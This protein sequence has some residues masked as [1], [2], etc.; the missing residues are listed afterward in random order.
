MN[1]IIK[2]FISAVK[3]HCWIIILSFL[4][5]ILIFAPLIAFP[6]VIKNE[7]Q[8]ININ[9]FGA[10]AHFYFSRAREVLDGHGL[11]SPWLREGKNDAD[12][13]FSYVDYI[14]LAPI[15]LLGLEQ[16]VDLVAIYNI[17]NFIG[18]FFI[19]LM[20]YFLVYQLSGKKIL[21]AAAALFVVGGYSIIFHQALFYDDSNIYSRIIDP[22]FA[23]LI[24]F[25][26]LNLLVKASKSAEVKY[27]I[28]S[29]LTFGLLFYIYFYAWSF[30]LALN[31]SLFLVLLIKKDF[32]SAKKILFISLVGL[33][34]GSYTLIGL[35]SSLGSAYGEQ[36][37][38][39]ILMS[40]GHRPVFS[41]I[42]LI[43][44]VLL[45]I[46]WYKKRDDQNLPFISAIILAGWIALNQQIITGK[47]I[48]YG[49][50]YWY[51]VVPLSI[52]TG[53]YLIWSLIKNEKLKNYLFIFIIFIVFINTIGGQY[54]SFFF[55]LEA[56]K[57]EQ[58]FRSLIDYLN[59]DNQSAVILAVEGANE[60][61]FTI[62]TPHD[63]FWNSGAL[64]GRISIQR[65]K[66]TLFVYSYLNKD[67][68]NNFKEYFNAADN[69]K[70][71]ADFYLG[72][73]RG[74]EGYW[75]GFSFYEYNE[76][77]KNNDS[78]LSQNRSAII[79]RLY[80]EYND[81][82]LKDNGIEKILKKYGVNYI[83][84]DKNKNPEWDLN[85]LLDFKPVLSSNN[86]YLYS[87]A[88]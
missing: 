29:A 30:T 6:Y 9:H 4:L 84:W 16:K 85:A 21:S 7:Y 48:Q 8:G 72:L 34:L 28:F 58:N 24:F 81:T 52:I 55:T 10:D 44:L 43:T 17:Y 57:Y 60:N 5:T 13:F 86:I 36:A 80:E 35:L 27:K 68:R 49:H 18:V 19:I 78:E 31:G 88:N 56:K 51:F 54:K 65:I 69:N 38:Y 61:L 15:K 33:I 12:T 47:M 71:Q 1:N 53:F 76:K 20:I 50:Y 42:G 67:V 2:K 66:D 64:F 77:I 63:L 40:S 83:V 73:Y 45:A 11:G 39:F 82:V 25:I 14:L 26:Y 37:S 41:K 87:L 79:E 62:Y 75:S 74:L 3:E 59:Y 70:S 46:Y 22:Y 32:A 23:S